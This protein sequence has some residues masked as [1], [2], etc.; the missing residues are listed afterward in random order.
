MSEIVNT[1]PNEEL[2]RFVDE[3]TFKLWNFRG[4]PRDFDPETLLRESMEKSELAGY[5]F[6]IAK[7]NLCAAMGAFIFQN[8]PDLSFSFLNTAMKLFR[9]LEEKKWIA[10]THS[11]LGIINNSLGN[12]ET[13]LY[14]ALRGADYYD[15]HPEDP[16]DRVMAYYIIGTVYKDLKKYE[17]SEK[18]YL[19]GVS[20]E[21]FE[22]NNWGGR[23]YAGL[24]SMYTEREKYDTALEYCFKS[25]KKLETEK[26]GLGISRAYTEIGI[27][28][29]KRGDF[30]AALKYMMD[31]LKIREEHDLKQFIVSSHL[32]IATVYS[33]TGKNEEAIAHLEKAEEICNTIKQVQK[34]PKIFSELSQIHKM[35]GDFE[36]ALS[37]TE[38]LLSLNS[39]LNK[40]EMEKR[41]GSLQDSLLKEKAEEIEKIRNFELKMAYDLITEKNKEIMDSIQYA[42]RIQTALMTT[43][44]YFDRNLRRLNGRKTE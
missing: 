25:L 10:N 23:I 7:T 34:L 27:I 3:A 36:K 26:N 44:K 2:I 30:D 1:T 32:E 4:V 41:I 20:S 42:K 6:G 8:N 35:K 12:S 18:Y 31:G 43:E 9:S 19:R 29:K 39:E 33:E 15:N 28:Y 14:N 40:K 38:K 22:I 13:A 37:Y 17:E 16:Y 5:T 11:I 21:D 24:A